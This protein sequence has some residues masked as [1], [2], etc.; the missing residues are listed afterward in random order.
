MGFIPTRTQDQ[1]QRQTMDIDQFRHKVHVDP[2]TFN[3][4]IKKIHDHHIFH[5]NLHV[6]QIPV[7][8]Q[9]AIFLYCAR[10]Y[11]SAKINISYFILFNLTTSYSSYFGGKKGI[12]RNKTSFFLLMIVVVIVIIV[13][14]SSLSLLLCCCCHCHVFVFVVA[15]LSSLLYRCCLVVVTVAIAILLLLPLPL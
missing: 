2:T 4:I 5:N 7:E 8:T 1:S 9:L 15:L 10:H 12:S 14:T 13:V 11:A 3:G 6:P